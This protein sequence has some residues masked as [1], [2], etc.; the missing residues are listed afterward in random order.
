MS[1]T[2]SSTGDN[3]INQ[4]DNSQMFAD[5]FVTSVENQAENMIPSTNNKSISG[6]NDT[7]MIPDCE[8]ESSSSVHSDTGNKLYC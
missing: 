3:E 2:P 7:I 5:N 8:A 1:E 4:N 6:S